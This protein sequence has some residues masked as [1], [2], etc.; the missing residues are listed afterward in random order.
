M[1]ENFIAGIIN[2]H[3]DKHVDRRAKQ[4]SEEFGKHADG[5]PDPELSHRIDREI[6]RRGA[7]GRQLDVYEPIRWTGESFLLAS[8]VGVAIKMSTEKSFAKPA[9]ITLLAT[10]G[11]TTAIQLVRIPTRYDAGL[12][13]GVDTARAMQH[14]DRHHEKLHPEAPA[15][16]AEQM[17]KN[18]AQPHAYDL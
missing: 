17:R 7:I 2:R 10:T 18:P 15:T 5:A 11:L 16:W 9:L 1:T 14:F 12:R 4:W 6:H 3:L 8:A 13:G